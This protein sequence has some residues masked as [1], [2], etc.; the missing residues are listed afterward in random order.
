MVPVSK[1]ILK[2]LIFAVLAIHGAFPLW[3]Y[4]LRT[5]QVFD[6]NSLSG[7]VAYAIIPLLE[8]A[9]LLVLAYGLGSLFA[10]E[11][12]AVALAL[13]IG[14][15]GQALFFLGVCG[16]FSATGIAGLSGLLAIASCFGFRKAKFSFLVSRR[17]DG[18][19]IAAI[20]V[21]L[22]LFVLW[23]TLLNALAPVTD[24]DALM[25]HLAIP[26]L[27]LA[28]GAIREIPWLLDAHWPHLVQLIYAI[29]LVLQH[30]S[31]AALMHVAAHAALIAVVFQSADEYLD[32]PSAWIAA[33]IL[34]AQP[35]VTTFAGTPR[36]DGW[37]ALD[38]FLAALFLWRWSLMPSRRG[39]VL[40]GV[41]AG[42]GAAT[43]LIGV[44]PL[45]IL[46]AWLLIPDGAR[47]FSQRLKNS[48]I[49]L[50]SAGCVA[51]PWYV[52]TWIGAGNP[53]WPFA[54]EIFGGKWNAA[55]LAVQLKDH[56]SMPEL[57]STY[58]L[59]RYAPQ[60]LL[61]PLAVWGVLALMP[62]SPCRKLPP[63]LRFLWALLIPYALLVGRSYE[64]WR[65]LLPG[66]PVMVLTIAWMMSS[67]IQKKR[68]WHTALAVIVGALAVYPIFQLTQGN[69]LFAV[70][71]LRSR[72]FPELSPREAYLRRSFPPYAFE[73]EV[74]SYVRSHSPAGDILLFPDTRGYY[75]DVPYQ[76]GSPIF[77]ARIQPN[78][79]L[80]MG[81]GRILISA[82]EFNQLDPGTIK[83]MLNLLHDYAYSIPALQHGPYALYELKHAE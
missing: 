47:S 14:I 11:E 24:F 4:I 72:D 53:V 79:L 62:K 74:N 60:A 71:Q 28:A 19:F 57:H 83:M 9:F 38:T 26:K 31:V 5:P 13:G 50:V 63:F 23:H 35:L 66:F 58:F 56:A 27:Y 32:R 49:L 55:A 12:P 20:A 34:A 54:S 16:G 76:W 67:L 36:V 15:W 77:Q 21:G 51:G 18:N 42:L 39:L 2:Y 52:K 75:L 78:N 46:A 64:V 40:A 7:I 41:L 81:V 6:G 70:L 22:L 48:L 73:Q 33:A 3:L 61:I 10:P 17:V 30:D 29:P 45:I 69:A 82:D 44:L 43:K 80:E 1:R 25:A 65:Y 68:S 59:F 8:A 37:W